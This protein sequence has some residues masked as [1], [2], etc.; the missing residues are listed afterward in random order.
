MQVID[1][2][3]EINIGW[4]PKEEYELANGDESD[5][6]YIESSPKKHF[7][8]EEIRLVHDSTVNRTFKMFDKFPSAPTQSSKPIEESKIIPKQ[9]KK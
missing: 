7:M 2:F 5:E 1:D 9:P 3:L 8:E 6:E 4:S